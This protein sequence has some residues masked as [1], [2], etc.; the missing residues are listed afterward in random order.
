MFDPLSQPLCGM[1]A[2]EASAG[3]G[4]T[5]S[6]TLLWLRLL[7][8]EDLQ[9]DEILVSTFTRA[10]TAELKERLLASLRRATAAAEAAERQLPLPEY[11]EARVLANALHAGT[12]TPAA[13]LQKLSAAL[14]SFDL[15][16]IST[17][18]G[19]CQTLI[20]RHALEL[21]CDP[22]LTLI[23]NQQRFL[24]DILTDTVLHFSDYDLPEIEKLPDH[25]RKVA[26]PIAARPGATLQVLPDSPEALLARRLREDLPRRKTQAG[27][28]TFDDI[29][30]TIRDALQTQGPNG[31]LAQAVR[32]RLRAAI[33]DE[34]Q[35]SDTTQIHV[36]QTLFHHPDTRAFLVIGDPKQSIYR[37]RGADLASYKELATRATAADPMQVNYRSDGPLISALNFLY[38][39]HFLFPDPPHA[40]NPAPPTTYIPVRADHPGSRIHDP[41]LCAALL[42]HKTAKSD[43]AAAKRSLAAWIG[44]ECARLLRSNTT[45]V[46]RASQHTRPVEPGDIAVLAATKNDL[47]LVRRALLAHGIPCQLDGKG[48]GSV[49][50]S[51]EAFDLLA[52]LELLATFAES[53]DTLGKLCTLLATPLGAFP[54]ANIPSLRED[55][56]HIAKLCKH[57]RQMAALL[58]RSGPLPA[59]MHHLASPPADPHASPPHNTAHNTA[60][61]APS[62]GF[63]ACWIGHERRTTNWRHLAGLLQTRFANGLRTAASLGAWLAV[64]IGSPSPATEEAEGESALMKL[65]T[66]DSALQLLTI[67]ASKGL[68]YPIVFCPFL[69]DVRSV[70]SA[71]STMKVAVLRDR[72]GWLLD[73][74]Q[75]I[76]DSVKTQALQQEHEEEHRKL[77]V[78][79]TRARHRMYLGLADIPDGKG[80]HANGSQRS[81][82][83]QLP[84]LQ[85]ALHHTPTPGPGDTPDIVLLP[86][87]T[88]VP[89][90]QTRPHPGQGASPTQPAPLPAPRG[91]DAFARYPVFTKR[92]FS[93]LCRAAQ[94]IDEHLHKPDHDDDPQN[95]DRTQDASPDILK[96][97]G[98]AGAELGDQLHRALE[99]YLGNHIDLAETI[100][101]YAHPE[102]WR[103][104]LSTIVHTNLVFDGRTLPLNQ[105]RGACVTEMQFQ[106]P[107][108]YFCREALSRAL[109]ED[110]PIR[111]SEARTTWAA[112]FAEWPITE[113]T[114]FFQGFMDLIFEHEGRW[115]VMDYKSNQLRG[116]NE[117]QLESAML[118]HHY[119]LQ[120]RIYAVALHRHLQH[121]LPDYCFDKH[122]GGVVYLFVRALPHGGVWFERSDLPSLESLA[123]LFST[124]RA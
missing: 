77:Y 114:G 88:A 91:T 18:H 79:L 67:H 69:W 61:N 107:T 54:C 44:S 21:G 110:T 1:H 109:L 50:A 53:G 34:C 35:D 120:A 46:D 31:P 76:P 97:L 62:P 102:A 98:P 70:R 17:I 40:G 92:S 38:G 121:H 111:S 24:E 83:F 122:F 118:Q 66:D 26:A 36:F 27:V 58:N 84:N 123:A 55:P 8:E 49:F 74:S 64:Q 48:L 113:F 14:S 68:E 32:Q 57:Y 3:T 11:P 119:L 78:A 28:R 117:E 72:Q 20:G 89:S 101:S 96:A 52:W 39:D 80:G 19:F 75:P 47:R 5:F 12:H 43:R 56:F 63:N 103:E 106:M 37:F 15:A 93:S 82:L 115:Y 59:L 81:A 45:V 99:N 94:N 6:I 4:K 105:I 65:E 33:I 73:A 87:D 29:L 9:V 10:A 16:P 2:I 104:A 25:L 108:A 42:F 90:S 22:A 23:E 41:D 124:Q 116:Y 51:D 86:D 85:T 13:L 7:V 95:T 60:H 100:R 30:L 112:Q 71:K